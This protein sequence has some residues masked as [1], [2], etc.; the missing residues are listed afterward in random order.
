MGH[1]DTKCLFC[2][3]RKILDTVYEN[4]IFNNKEFSYIKCA[5]CKLIFV[6]PL[7]DNDDY[8]EM[9]P[10]SY[11]G[12]IIE[13]P[14]G[15]YDKLFSMISE[16]FSNLNTILDYGCGNGRFVI[17]ALDK[18]FQVT[19]TE[20]NPEIVSQL[21]KKFSNA[22]FVT[23]D[24]FVKENNTFD[25]IFLSNVLEHLTNPKEVMIRLKDK[26]NPNGI[27]ILEGPI[28][29]NFTLKLVFTKLIFSIRKKIFGKK[30]NHVPTHI[31]Y[32]NKNNQEN[33]F[34][35]VGLETLY[36]NIEED[37]WPF[38]STLESS[39]GLK[40]KLMYIVAK[41]SIFFSNI[42]NFWGDKFL[43]IGKVKK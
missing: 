12:T 10:V 42:F 29:A 14:V 21:S 7:P 30:T 24:D 43:Y 19:G 22:R 11:Q 23:I 1:T 38:P 2:D 25:A 17:E 32:S 18:G 28:E 5:S 36:Y 9:Y 8:D 37:Y 3:S 20:Y 4:T 26:L 13:A 41:I 15:L 6:S 35:S 33:F 34:K 31:F 39:Q 40:Q 16:K 27:F